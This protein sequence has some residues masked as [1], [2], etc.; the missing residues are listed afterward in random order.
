MSASL[1]T[2]ETP[3]STLLLV[4]KH[5]GLT[6]LEQLTAVQGNCSNAFTPFVYHVD[7][8]TGL[9]TFVRAA[10]KMWSC[11]ECA[12]RNAKKWIARIIDGINKLDPDKWFFGTVTAHKWHRKEKSLINLR[13]NWHK[14][15]K[16]LARV[17]KQ[18]GKELHY[19]RVWEHHKDGSYHMHFIT[20]ISVSQ[21][22]LKSAASECGM[23]YMA[24]MEGLVNAGQA[25]GYVAKYMLKQ[26]E[27]ETLHTF[28]KGAHRIEVSSKWVKWH[29]KASENWHYGGDLE[30]ASSK[31]K[32]LKYHGKT[33]HDLAIRNEKKRIQNAYT[34]DAKTKECS[35]TDGHATTSSTR[36]SQSRPQK[37]FTR[38]HGSRP[39][40]TR[41]SANF[42]E[43]ITA[44]VAD[45]PKPT[46]ENERI[47]DGNQ[48]SKRNGIRRLSRQSGFKPTRRKTDNHEFVGPRDAAISPSQVDSAA[49]IAGHDAR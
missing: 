49:N 34:R 46:N 4:P 13:T 30:M 7:Q 28:P 22:W 19:V 10:C 32:M 23:G 11:P 14:L 40:A 31:A 16:R 42:E 43:G 1:A 3:I 18:L 25:A 36:T 45:A 21:K 17:A 9:I 26:S 41:R 39:V 15:R 24:H 33:V 37:P 20:N 44:T 8:K 2:L 38:S 12:L 48:I 27:A 5:E 47:L 35:G 6:F 29:D